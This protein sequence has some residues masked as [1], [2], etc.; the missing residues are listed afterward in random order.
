[1]TLPPRP[2]TLEFMNTL[3]HTK[4]LPYRTGASS[5]L[6]IFPLLMPRELQHIATT[7]PV[8]VAMPKWVSRDM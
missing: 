2:I 5:G 8:H 4:S 3:R 7:F 1:M 6:G